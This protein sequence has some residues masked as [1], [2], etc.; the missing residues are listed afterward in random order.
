MLTNTNQTQTASTTRPNARR[1]RRGLALAFCAAVATALSG[2]G[3]PANNSRAAF[4][5]VDISENYAS[6]MEKARTLTNHL[7]AQMESGDS[8][9]IGFIDNSSYSERNIIASAEF[10]H[11]PSV[12][13]QQKREVRADLDA[14]LERFRVP[15]AHSDITGGVFLARD[16][17]NEANAGERQLYM[18]S[19]LNEDLMPDLKR[20]IPLNLKGVDVVA[21]NV[22][23]MSGDN[24]DP[25]AYERRL[26]DWQERIE[27]GGGQWR[28]ANNLARLE[29]VTA[30]Q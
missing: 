21:V 30:Q 7:L 26:A 11:R 12:A 29:V 22:T 28:V 20:D 8:L 3:D 19:D 5:L 23:R 1:T 27:S 16:F 6:E 10:D 14:F 2:C 9:A 13:T 24:H 25:R 17:L 4:V 18:V 15:S